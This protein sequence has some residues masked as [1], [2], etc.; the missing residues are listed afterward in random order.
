MNWLS[1]IFRIASFAVTGTQTIVGDKASGATK[2]KIAT[3]LVSNE[4]AVIAPTLGTDNAAL[5]QAA[6]S[7]TTLAINQAV[8]IQKAT[9]AYQ[10]A[11]AAAN[12]AQQDLGVTAAVA[13]LVQ[14]I[15]KPPTP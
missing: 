3:D 4:L 1:L 2:A 8:T 7:V 12:A 15:E 13:A 10:K 6:A 14:S 5:A 9:G 11:T